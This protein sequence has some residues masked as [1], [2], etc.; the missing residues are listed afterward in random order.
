MAKLVMGCE[1]RGSS[2][3]ETGWGS[4]GWRWGE[5]EGGRAERDEIISW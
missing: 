3:T 1:T 2:S 5:S 4:E